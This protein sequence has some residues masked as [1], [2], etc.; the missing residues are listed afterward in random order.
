MTHVYPNEPQKWGGMDMEMEA[1]AP[2][3]G[4]AQ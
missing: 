4:P 3:A 2:E 1:G